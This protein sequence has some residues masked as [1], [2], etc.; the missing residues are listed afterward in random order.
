MA[1]GK[2]FDVVPLHDSGKGVA[3]FRL[4]GEM[5]EPHEAMVLAHDVDEAIQAGFLCYVFDFGELT[6]LH[7]SGWGVLTTLMARISPAGGAV[8]LTSV[9]GQPYTFIQKTPDSEALWAFNIARDD[10]AVQKLLKQ[11]TVSAG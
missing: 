8:I 7:E 4:I 6:R 2:Q 1:G 3:R 9:W 5:I 11:Y 10:S